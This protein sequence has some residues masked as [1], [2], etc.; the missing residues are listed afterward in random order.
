[1]LR[2]MSKLPLVASLSLLAACTAASAESTS[3][4][5]QVAQW[6][7]Q[8]QGQTRSDALSAD[9][10]VALRSVGDVELSP[11]GKW[12]AYTLRMP[13][14]LDDPGGS[15]N[16]IWIAPADGR[17]EPRPYTQLEH[18]SW[19]P[20][21]SPDGKRLAF[22]SARGAEGVQVFVLDV[23]GG[24]AM[25]LFA[26]E[27]S[28]R[29]YAWSA[30]GKSVAFTSSRKTEDEQ[31]SHDQG[32][33]WVLDEGGG[34]KT[35]LFVHD[36]ESGEEREVVTSGENV[37]DFAWS[38]NMKRFVV[39]AS[40]KATTDFTMMYSSLH[41]VD[42]AGGKLE[43][44]TETAGKLGHIAWSPDS[45]HVAFLGAADISDPT[46]GVVY[47]VPASGGKARALTKDFLGT[48]AW[49]EFDTNNSV[50]FLANQG[51][52]TTLN[53]IPIAGGTP[54]S[55]LKASPICHD[56][57]LAPKG[58]LACAGDSPTHPREVFAGTLKRGKLVRATVSNPKLATRTL[59]EQSVVTWKAKDGLEIEGVLVKP[60][61]YEE[62]KRYPLAVLPHG[63][64]EGISLDGWGTGAN[65]PVQIFAN[66]GYMVLQPNYRGSQGR[67]VAFGKADQND[68]GGK[69]FEDV[70]AG[71]DYLEG[72]G[73]INREQ[74]GMG[75]WS[76]GGYFSGLAATKYTEHF[77]A[78]MIAAAVINWVSFTGTTEIEHENSLVHWN[79]W[80][81]D[82]FQLPWER[83]P[84]A[85]IAKSKTAALVVHG[86]ADER[87]PPGQGLE[88]YRGL[89]HHG[90]PTQLVM[91]PREPHGLRENVHQVDF[92][93]R[94]VGWF[95][96]YVLAQ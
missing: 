40:K 12:V 3:P 48:G 11:D 73:L 32:R 71:L 22:A 80:P 59:G 52:R 93:E 81:W 8:T 46:A 66:R 42:A 35:R 83:S 88:I 75:G 49:V 90:V 16:Q 4:E 57:S 27:S 56:V 91:Y 7:A 61:G 10:V 70:I 2:R 64:P 96:R 21:W 36:L 79:Q 6:I 15:R 78:V 1:M 28:V 20:R 9:D 34:T 39:R 58:R 92:I 38:P 26:S 17:T 94:F 85:H 74:V 14:G 60:V 55:M 44:L 72:E 30:D 37:V 89:K 41:T 45:E 13:R 62:G 47:V 76:Y 77:K 31:K 53:R 63:G 5:P 82:D 68:L 43:P 29:Q 65:Y 51:T 18:S 86:L 87:V 33:D 67:G 19:A 95:D 69:E 25:P 54:R 84:L 23:E 50:V 24:E